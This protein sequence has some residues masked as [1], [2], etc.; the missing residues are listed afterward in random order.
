[1]TDDIKLD[2]KDDGG[3]DEPEVEEPDEQPKIDEPKE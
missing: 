2:D 3:P 1:V